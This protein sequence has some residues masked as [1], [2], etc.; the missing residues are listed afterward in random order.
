MRLMF[1]SDIHGNA[2]FGNQLKKIFERE[3]PEKLILLGDLLY[4]K[5]I[6][7]FGR[8]NERQ[9]TAGI[10]NDL[11]DYIIA[12]RGNCDTDLD[13]ALL[14]FP[15]MNDYKKLTVDGYEFFIT[16][17]HLYNKYHLPPSNKKVILIHG[18]THIPCIENTKEYLYLN[19]GSI[20]D[21]REGNPNTYMIYEN[22]EF[23]IK[24]LEGY[25]LKSINLDESY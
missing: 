5:S 9:K 12:V 4:N 25:E 17:G 19:P 3:K 14:Y 7:S 23:I 13:Q 15:M 21:P 24:D 20:S 16:H 6:L 11:M 22:K 18:H 1:A 2:Y 10:L 8:N